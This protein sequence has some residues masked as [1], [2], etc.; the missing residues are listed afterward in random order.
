[1]PAAPDADIGPETAAIIGLRAN[2]SSGGPGAMAALEKAI[3]A[4]E[5]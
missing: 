3:S 4:A 1:M 5:P 2:K